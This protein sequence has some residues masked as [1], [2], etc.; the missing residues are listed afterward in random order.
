LSYIGKFDAT[1][2]FDGSGA[3]SSVHVHGDH[4][5][6]HA[7]A[8]AI[9]VPDAQL[10]FNGDFKRSGIDLVLSKDHREFVLQDYFKGEKR[11]AL[12]SP[13]GAHLTGDI[14]YA[15]T[16]EV[17]LSQ[18]GGP[19]NDHHFIG[20][21]TKLQ[22]GATAIR[23]G[24]SI[25]LNIG[26]N[27]EKGD[28][29]QSG[30]D[31]TLGITFI[32]GTVFG[33]SSNARMVLN[34][35][36]Y[37]PN[38]SNNSS[39]ISLVAGTISFV[40]GET[41]KHGDMKVDTPVA[42]MGIRGT[43]VL[44]EIDFT[45]PSQGGAP[46]A[47]FQ[48]LVEPDGT[49]GSYILYDKTTL[50]PMA[51]VNQAGQ[52]INISQGVLS[53]STEPLSADVQKLII[54]VFSLKFSDATNT[55]TTT[56][57]TDTLNPFLLGQAIELASGPTATPIFLAVNA[58]SNSS[59][60]S[61]SNDSLSGLQHI[62]LPPTVVVVNAPLQ[63]AGTK[64][65]ST[66]DTVS[67]SIR[68]ADINSGDTPTV[69][70]AFGSFTLQDADHNDI[71]STLTAQ[72]LAEIQAIEVP[73]TLVPTPGN[74]NNGSVTWT[75]SIPDE[76][77]DFL[78]YGET[79]TLTYLA[80]VD[81]NYSQLN[82]AVV[83]PITITITGGQL[84]TIATTNGSITE[85]PG[86]NNAT[87]DHATGTITVT[88]TDTTA[89]PVVTTDFGSFE[90][91]NASH[92]DVTSSLTAQQE[93]D[94]AA[95]ES[96]LTLT[97]LPANNGSVSWSYDVVDGKLDFLG[98][99]QT[100]TLTYAATVNDGHGN[101]VTEP[102]TVT[103]TGTNDQPTIV[104]ESNPLTQHV[105]VIGSGEPTVLDQGINTNS[106]DLP[107]ETFD[108]QPTGSLSTSGAGSG[109][110][111]SAALD[112]SFSGSGNTGVVNGSSSD[113]KAPF[114]GPLP[115]SEDA[116]N[117]LSIGGG[118]TETITFA[119]SENA[120]GLYWGSLDSY[121]MIEFYDG[122]TL[123]ASFTGNDI[124]PLFASGNQASFISNGY[125]EFLGIAPFDK[126][127][128][129]SAANAFEID[130]ISAGAIHAQ[131]ATPISGTLSVN[132]A[133]I[134]DAL[135][136][137]VIGNATVEYNGSTT[138][139]GNV[140]ADALAAASAITFDTVTSNG[141][142]EVLN[143]TYNPT[144]PDLDFL[145]PGDTLNITYQ[146]QVSDGH[147]SVG[148][149]PLTISVVGTDPTANMSIDSGSI[150]DIGA[151]ST[152]TVTFANNSDTSGLL[153]LNAPTNFTGLISGFTGNGTLA[154]SD[155]I[156]LKAINYNSSSFSESYNSTDDTLSV[157][158]GTNS[159]VLHF[160]GNYQAENFNFVAD[161][162][163]GTIVY[164][165]PVTSSTASVAANGSHD[166][167][168]FKPD[169]DQAMISK[170]SPAGGDGIETGHAIAT[171]FQPPV[172]LASSV[173]ERESFTA[174]GQDL[175]HVNH[176]ASPHL[177]S[178]DFHLI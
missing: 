143:W 59:S 98:A 29:V 53:Q 172:S 55:K 7:P 104:G 33:L 101:L 156:D 173:L 152:A 103:I 111:F 31:S 178:H 67:G 43:A 87:I 42:T 91:Q 105:V 2:F 39:L 94:I 35:M 145:K 41:A 60:H 126:V 13:D 8:G 99:S 64:G 112:A 139:P 76:K 95:I 90:Y 155:Q 5:P 108:N 54:D 137:S 18:A 16:G 122:T 26:D 47:K 106:I 61:N 176:P 36:V 164:D 63:G 72:Q 62:D 147:G 123:V 58:N 28:V 135:T 45:V 46:D 127:V 171:R 10:L 142:T 133:D 114:V 138:L 66:I 74:N 88:D 107:T 32:D 121:N 132:D 129:E 38:G 15:L 160:I 3:H 97:L 50:A 148:D 86:T 167:F 9:L 27:V 77:F 37:D 169:L 92:I 22:G 153:V 125:V 128:L 19:A 4:L 11:A 78:P 84:P 119:S 162:N 75:Y 136:A 177:A 30:S 81:S 82:L 124:S 12:A 174:D 149:Q 1:L 175:L 69:K 166:G 17:Q 102:L 51:T 159:T 134:G 161:G 165:P 146:T 131:L 109:E 6:A 49:T 116:T 23:N 24:V 79:L 57:Q 170:S 144:G 56:A 73:L 20:H 115:G 65:G 89:H 154:G 34:E 40:A 70:V 150:L 110:F 44:V 71:S 14:V 118:G 120:F 68:F 21:V 151:P 141:G 157:S 140:S 52:Q 130:N 93:A 96:S 85:L 83:K 100:L 163:G 117:Y 80:E 25:I 113:T 48:V 158:D 168:I